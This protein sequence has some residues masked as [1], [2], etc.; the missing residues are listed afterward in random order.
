MPEAGKPR[1]FSYDARVN[2]MNRRRDRIV[3]EIERNRKGD[4]AVPTWVLA[5]VLVLIVAGVAAYEIFT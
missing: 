5:A 3:A 2:R 1:R 4:F